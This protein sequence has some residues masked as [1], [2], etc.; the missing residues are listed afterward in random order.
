METD[1]LE[2]IRGYFQNE[3]PDGY[4]SYFKIE[5]RQLWCFDVDGP[6]RVFRAKF[7]HQFMRE[8]RA[9]EIPSLL[10]SW[11]IPMELRLAGDE[12][13]SVGLYRNW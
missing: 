3:F 13:I 6:D 9:K 10:D 11:R 4:I 7:T 1:K 12:G 2:A 8:H 5:E